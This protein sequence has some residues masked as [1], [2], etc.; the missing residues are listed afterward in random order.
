[1]KGITLLELII[2]IGII[3]FIAAILWGAFLGFRESGRLVE[4][5]T[6]I[7]GLLRDA[8]ARTLASE[9]NTTYGVHFETTKSVL[10]RGMMYNSSD[11]TNENYV[12]SP[13]IKISSTNLTDGASDVV[14]TRLEGT[15]TA[16]GTI[17]I[18]STLDASKTKTITILSSGTVQ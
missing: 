13:Y 17:T 5:H 2:S 6:A 15:T 16:F 8:R 3:A 7:L 9:L 1:M 10:F 11:S 14:F 12:F 4:G 18:Q